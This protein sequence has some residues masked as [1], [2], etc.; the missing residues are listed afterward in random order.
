MVRAWWPSTTPSSR[1]SRQ[2]T[3]ARSSTA[4][5]P[6]S[7]PLARPA[8]TFSQPLRFRRDV[9]GSD[10]S[11]LTS[12]GP[13]S[14][15]NKFSIFFYKYRVPSAFCLVISWEESS[16]SVYSPPQRPLIFH[17]VKTITFDF[18]TEISL[19]SK[20]N[21]SYS[22]TKSTI[23]LLG[24]LAVLPRSTS[25]WGVLLSPPQEHQ[26][27]SRP[28]ASIFG[29]SGLI[30]KSPQQSLFS[31]QCLGV[32]IKHS[33]WG[34]WRN[35]LHRSTCHILPKAENYFR[36]PRISRVPLVY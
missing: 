20:K 7:T 12:S 30:R 13:S 1:G 5:W 16:Q 4:V 21:T 3:S 19:I 10:S 9:P 29:P 22:I 2:P 27:R 6:V 32:W 34:H 31:L 11:N 36:N 15:V 33:R 17:A 35:I 18:L 25:W 28:S 8:L 26:P 23:T 24:E 14:N